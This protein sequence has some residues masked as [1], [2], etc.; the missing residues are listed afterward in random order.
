MFDYAVLYQRFDEGIQ[1]A[2]CSKG[3][4]TA[5]R[6]FLADIHKRCQ[7]CVKLD[8][9]STCYYDINLSIGAKCIEFAK[10]E[11]ETKCKESLFADLRGKM[12]AWTRKS[13]NA[14]TAAFVRF[15]NGNLPESGGVTGGVGPASAAPA[16][17]PAIQA[18]VTFP[19]SAPRPANSDDLV[20]FSD[21]TGGAVPVSAAPVAPAEQG[22]LMDSS[23]VSPIRHQAF[24]ATNAQ[25]PRSCHV[26]NNDDLAV[27]GDESGGAVPAT[28]APATHGNHV[29]SLRVPDITSPTRSRI[30]RAIK[31]GDD[32]AE[33]A[34]ISSG[35]VSALP[36]PNG[37]RV[38][39]IKRPAYAS[40]LRS[41]APSPI[42]AQKQRTVA[43]QYGKAASDVSIYF[44]FCF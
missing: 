27:S 3:L 39:D 35:V 26:D 17:A 36:A 32:L 14:Y 25:I 5:A 10:T 13:Q 29:G 11:E 42:G 21:M 41:R 34:E 43:I 8:P 9:T 19:T 20:E 30:P 22:P 18:P 28:T 1:Y 24:P 38:S 23:H 6:D 7:Y 37:R 40:P 16:L 31:Y 12:I 33:S 15:A 44:K 4:L 2:T